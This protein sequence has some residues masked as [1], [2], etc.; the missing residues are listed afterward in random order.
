MKYELN[1]MYFFIKPRTL[2]YYPEMEMRFLC[3]LW[4]LYMWEKLTI[5][6]ILITGYQHLVVVMFICY[7]LKR[8]YN[9]ASV[10]LLVSEN[11]TVHRFLENVNNM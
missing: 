2:I 7:M 5:L 6:M 1:L 4:C 8:K 9:L 3:E 10:I 11:N